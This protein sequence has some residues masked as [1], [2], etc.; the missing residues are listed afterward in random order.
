MNIQDRLTQRNALVIDKEIARALGLP[1]ATVLCRVAWWCHHNSLEPG[2]EST[3]YHNGMWW[4][5]NT[6]E[7]WEKDLR[8]LGKTYIRDILSELEHD[9][10]ILSAHWHI[11][12]WDRTK[13]YTVNIPNVERFFRLW[14]FHGAPHKRDAKYEDPWEKYQAELANQRVIERA[15]EAIASDA[16][17]APTS[18]ASEALTSNDSYSKTQKDVA[19]ES[20]RISRALFGAL[21]QVTPGTLRPRGEDE[22]T[23]WPMHDPSL[24]DVCK[25]LWRVFSPSN[26]K[27]SV[28]VKQ[29]A[30]LEE[31]VSPRGSYD[32]YP[33]PDAAYHAHPKAFEEFLEK[34]HKWMKGKGIGI[35]TGNIIKYVRGYD[36]KGI[37][38][39][40]HMPPVA[41][42]VRQEESG[43]LLDALKDII[44]E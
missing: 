31:S 37:G 7:G 9:G 35:N 14:D 26:A 2:K 12:K 13:W 15:V 25:V 29:K 23:A 41:R 1:A 34:L 44:G 19:V 16:S 6:L 33:S 38:W 3:H 22:R 42:T 21:S 11:D 36:Y 5:Y 40:E 32:R 28:S 24:P 8:A 43:G 30:Q 10:F 17:E 18:H 39:F 4:M 27:L 20:A